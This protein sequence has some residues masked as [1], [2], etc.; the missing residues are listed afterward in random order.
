MK[1]RMASI[2]V[3]LL[4]AAGLC[5]LTGCGTGGSVGSHAAGAAASGTGYSGAASNIGYDAGRAA[6]K[7]VTPD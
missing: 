5:G 6:E 2:V 7:A 4:A 3:G 1:L